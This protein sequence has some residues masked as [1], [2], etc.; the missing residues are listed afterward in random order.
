MRND[1]LPA[2]WYPL[3]FGLAIALH[4][5]LKAQGL[6]LLAALYIPIALVAIGIVILERLDPARLD[7]RPRWSDVRADAAFMLVVQV[8]LPR[9][10]ALALALVVADRIHERAA[11]DLWPHHWPIAVQVVLMVLAVDFMRYWLHRASHTFTPLWRLHEVHHSPDL[12]YTLNVGRFHPLEKVLQFAL[13]TVPFVLLGVAPP[14]IAGYFLAYSVNGFFQHSNLRLRYGWLNHLVGSAE[15]HRW[16]HARDPKTG[17]CNFGNTV[18]VWDHLFGTWYLPRSRALDIGIPDRTYPKS[19]GAQLLAPFRAGSGSPRGIRQRLA[20]VVITS[21]LRQAR[22]A[23]GRKVAAAA[24]DPMRAQDALLMRLLQENRDTTFGRAHGFAAM[25]GYRDFAERVPVQ[26]YEAVRRYVE[27]TIAT[28][29]SALTA[30]RPV[31]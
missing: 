15:T 9:L 17:Y 5:A 27:A 21:Q 13:D 6:P 1:L 3:F 19:F 26:D 24:R 25:R 10:L 29:E 8:V 4:V 2:L 28:G 31:R 23:L 14:V 20:D 11:N 7:W 12:L 16:H 18:I 22:R 30:E